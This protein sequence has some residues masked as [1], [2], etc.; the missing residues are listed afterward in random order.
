MKLLACMWALWAFALCSIHATKD[1]CNAKPKDLPLE[2]MCIYR[3]PD[4]IQPNK[5]P[6]NIPVGTNP[7]VWE[8]SKA[9]SRFALSLFKQLAEGKSNDE[10]IF[11]SPISIST[12][13]AMTK[14]GACNTTLEQLMKVFQFDTIKE[15]TSDQVHFFF[16][17]LNCRLYRK[18]HETTELISAN[19]LF[20]DKSTTFNET[21]QHISETVY[22]AKLMP[23]DFKEKPEASRI[24]INEWI[25]NKTENRIKDTLPEGSI[26]T[27]TILVLVN[28]IYFKGQWKN[29]FDKQNVMKLDFHVSPTHKCPVPMMYQEKKFQYAKIPED[30]VKI[31]ELPY[32][33]G[34][35]TMV[36]ILPIE[37]ATLSEVVANMNL[38][39]LVGWLHAMKET[40]VAVQIPRFR[41]EDSFSLKEQ[42]TKM[43]LEDLFSPANASLPGMVADAEGPN[44]FI[45]DAYHKAFLE[46]N[47]EGSEASAA[48]AVVATGRSLNIFRE[49]FVADRPFLLFIRESSINALIFTGRVANPC[50]SS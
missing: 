30:K 35:I 40:T 17:K 10:N 22:G 5:E 8:L 41:V 45:S 9:N 39:K 20:G 37:G 16:A 24:T 34:D 21:F 2:P 25:A 38:K 46:V 15:K 14:L 19:R 4:E 29:K 1:I 13:F 23:L 28:A 43:G 27:N 3:N 11:L 44:L 7:R 12:A 18:K 36:L 31:L 47:E 50:R 33:G 42:L 32:N 26:D 48:T 6:E 49:Q